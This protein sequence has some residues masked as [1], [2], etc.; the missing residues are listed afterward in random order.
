MTYRL[1]EKLMIWLAW[2]LPRKLV[3][4]CA[5]RVGAHATTG[6][7]G[8]TFVPELTFMDAMQRWDE[9]QPKGEGEQ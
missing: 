8:D 5:Y 2:R 4:W 7:F 3:M 6:K 9:P 1:T